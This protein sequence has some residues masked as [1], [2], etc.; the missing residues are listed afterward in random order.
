MNVNQAPIPT[1]GQR[2]ASAKP[3]PPLNIGDHH[4]RRIKK[5][6]GSVAACSTGMVWMIRTG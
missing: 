6:V 4:G 2:I 5:R 3:F 1:Q